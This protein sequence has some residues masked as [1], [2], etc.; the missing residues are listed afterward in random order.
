MVRYGP[1]LSL[2]VVLAG[3]VHAEPTLGAE[4]RIQQ[5][6]LVTRDEDRLRQAIGKRAAVTTS[7]LRLKAEGMSASWSYNVH[8][9]L[10]GT[11][12]SDFSVLGM[13]APPNAGLMD[14]SSD[15]NRG[16]HGSLEHGFDRV[17]ITYST[18]RAVVSLGRQALTWGRGQVFQPLDLFNPF[19]PDAPDRSY[20]PGADMAY[21]QYLFDNGADLQALVVPRRG[22]DGDLSTDHSS[23]ALKGLLPLGNVELEAVVASDYGDPVFAIGAAGPLGDA[24]WKFDVVA[25]NPKESG[26]VV[27]AVASLHKSWK[28]GEKPVSAFVE[29]YRNGFGVTDRRPMD[30][31]PDELTKRIARGQ[32]FTTGRDYLDVGGTINWT[33]LLSIT[34]TAIVNIN[35]RSIQALL[36]AEYSLSNQSN[37]IVSAQLPLGS[38]TTEFGGRQS[39]AAADVYERAPYLFF[40][41]FER[42]F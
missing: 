14:L 25:T 33:P 30:Q 9:V 12:S 2:L 7:S 16:R 34:P 37:L 40:V 18:P 15:I 26:T 29:Y 13:Q 23:A 3:P 10:Q 39:T 36:T 41:R 24:L 19:S 42:F 38:R 6:A 1:T 22:A 21:F 27:S 5:Q 17:F 28:W 11:Y 20:K 31:L 8:Y 35:D 32:I 4:L